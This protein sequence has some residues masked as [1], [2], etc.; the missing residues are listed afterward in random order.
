M[1]IRVFKYDKK[2]HLQDIY[3]FLLSR[4]MDPKEVDTLPHVGFIGYYGD[5]PV[6]AIFLRT[7]EGHIA[8]LD[9]LITDEHVDSLAR[10]LVIDELTNRVLA[11]A[12][13][14][15]FR[16]V[17]GFSIDENTIKRAERHGFKVLW[18]KVFSKELV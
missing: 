3:R 12:K 6:G 5:K 17:V 11:Y 9:S 13:E 7:C 16:K 14:Y 15:E 2:K 4:K 8:W 1:E 10:N 18:H